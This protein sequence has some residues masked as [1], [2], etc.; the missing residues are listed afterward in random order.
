MLDTK[1]YAAYDHTSPLRPF[2]LQRRDPGVRDVLIDILYCGVCHSDLHQVRNEWQTSAYPMVPGHEIVGRVARVGTTVT[3]FKPG[4]LVGVGCMVGSCGTCRSCREGLEQYCEKGFIGTYNALEADGKTPT[5]GGYSTRIV[6]DEDFVLR[7]QEGQSLPGVAPLLCAGITTYSPIRH[8]SVGPGHRLGVVGLGG[9]GHMAVK[10][11]RA[12]GAEV[13]VLSSS[14][15]K[16][17][18]ASRLGAHDFLLTSDE[19]AFAA[20][21]NRFDFL[22]DTVSAPHDIPA[23]TRLLR[24]DGTMII[25]GA[26]D[27]PATLPAFSLIF[28]RRSLAGSLIG[29]VRETQAMLDFCAKKS[30]VSEVE[31]IP[32]QQIDAAFDRMLRGDVRYRF[33]IDMQ[34]LG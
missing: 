11:G 32:I 28:G 29:G 18:A 6:T 23:Y 27:K 9:L 21:A 31:V 33:V 13:T 19:K 7:I 4:D 12:S 8:W 15:G 17:E 1:A 3:R 20:A 16:R 14:P 2:A 5:Y 25:V 34:S 10:F 30:I 24:R 26:P 22:L